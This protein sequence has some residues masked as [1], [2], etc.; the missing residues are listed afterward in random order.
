MS[1]AQRDNDL[2][3]GGNRNNFRG[4]AHIVIDHESVLQPLMCLKTGGWRPASI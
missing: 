4:L 1:D 2:K 3:L